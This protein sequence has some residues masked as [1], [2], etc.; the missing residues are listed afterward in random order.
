MTYPVT[1]VINHDQYNWP[2]EQTM[3]LQR[4]VDS[5]KTCYIL[6]MIDCINIHSLLK[7]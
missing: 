2:F 4:N 3:F 5:L 7:I 1:D 6:I